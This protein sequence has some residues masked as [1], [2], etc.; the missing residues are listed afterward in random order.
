MINQPRVLSKQQ[1]EEV[2]SNKVPNSKNRKL[3]KIEVEIQKTSPIKPIVK[4]GQGLKGP[5]SPSHRA[6]YQVPE[7][8]P[9]SR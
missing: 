4:S 5:S 3:E 8:K 9:K 2:Q 7:K 1:S 6:G